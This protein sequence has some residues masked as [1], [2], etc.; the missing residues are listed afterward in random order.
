MGMMG[1]L[2]ASR[3]LIILGLFVV[4]GLTV[5][6]I[7]RSVAMTSADT[8]EDI[9]TIRYTQNAVQQA[10]QAE[11]TP[12]VPLLPDGNITAEDTATLPSLDSIV[13]NKTGELVKGTDVSWLLDFAIIGFGKCGTSTVS[14]ML[15]VKC[16]VMVCA[17]LSYVLSSRLFSFPSSLL[18]FISFLRS[19]NGLA[20]ILKWDAFKRKY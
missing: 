4:A 18:L 20:I 12:I 7:T 16:C 8:K 6:M 2:F 3:P 9:Y 11:T 1:S 14:C 10:E 19:W 13:Y 17:V 15:C 5:S